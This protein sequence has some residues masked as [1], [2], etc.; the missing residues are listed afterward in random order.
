MNL[1]IDYFD[2][3][4]T[5]VMISRLSEDIMILR[6]TYVDKAC[7]VTQNVVQAVAGAVFLLNYKLA[8]FGYCD[9]NRSPNWNHFLCE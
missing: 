1:E 2:Q 9:C 4:S 3:T 5:G 6:E 8:C 7:Q